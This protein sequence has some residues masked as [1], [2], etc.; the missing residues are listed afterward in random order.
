MLPSSQRLATKQLEEV[1]GKGK[2]VHTPFFWLRFISSKD[3]TRVSVI[4][5]QKTIK[6]AVMRN[7]LRRKVYSVIRPFINEVKQH[8]HIILCVKEPMIKAETL[9]IK[10]KTKEIFVVAGLLK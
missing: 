7:L 2:V 3:N 9:Q 6:S 5:P 8:F 4:T 10:E 1:L